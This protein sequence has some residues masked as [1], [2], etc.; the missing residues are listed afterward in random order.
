MVQS[1]RMCLR[2]L[3][4]TVC[5]HTVKSLKKRL[6]AVI[7]HK[8]ATGVSVGVVRSPKRLA[9]QFAVK[10]Q[11][12]RSELLDSQPKQARLRGRQVLLLL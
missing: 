2:L 4:Y 3:T 5:G 6:I 9:G 8:F 12:E 10:H 11:K 1:K 7:A